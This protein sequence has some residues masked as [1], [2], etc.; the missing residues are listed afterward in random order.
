ML[1]LF[2]IM[3]W[4]VEMPLWLSILMTVVASLTI[5][6]KVIKGLNDLEN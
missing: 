6:G 5:L 4:V 2:I 1:V 3:A